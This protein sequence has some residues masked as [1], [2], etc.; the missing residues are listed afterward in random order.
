VINCAE[1]LATGSIHRARE[2]GKLRIE[3]R[4]YRVKDRDVI[5][6]KFAV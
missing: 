1:I 2:E 4:D 6:I 5:Q 3:G